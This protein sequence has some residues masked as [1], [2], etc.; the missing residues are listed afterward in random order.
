MHAKRNSATTIAQKIAVN[1]RLRSVLEILP[2]DDGEPACR[3]L[4]QHSDATIAAEFPGLSIHSVNY[5]RE[6]VYGKFP[7]PTPKLTAV[8]RDLSAE[9]EAARNRLDALEE[10]CG[11]LM[12]RLDA[13]LD[14]LGLRPGL[15]WPLS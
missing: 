13:L 1:D 11:H 8:E 3:Y 14:R 4:D 2:S 12:T 6:Q 5:I 10:C 7:R 15:K 9:L